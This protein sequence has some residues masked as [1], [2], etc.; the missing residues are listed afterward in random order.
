MSSESLISGENGCKVSFEQSTG[1]S[2]QQTRAILEELGLVL[3]SKDIQIG[4]DGGG[5]HKRSG[6]TNISLCNQGITPLQ[7]LQTLLEKSK[8]CSGDICEAYLELKARKEKELRVQVATVTAPDTRE[9]ENLQVD[10]PSATSISSSNNVEMSSCNGEAESSLL[11]RRAK[12]VSEK[13]SKNDTVAAVKKPL[14]ENEEEE[15]CANPIRQRHVALH[16]YYDGQNYSGLAENVGCEDDRSVER[17]LFAA[18]RKTQLIP[19]TS[20]STTPTEGELASSLQRSLAGY[21]RCGRTDRGVSAAGQVLAFRLKSAFGPRVSWDEDG[22]QLLTDD[23]LP[24]NSLQ[25]LNVF[26]FP[27]KKKGRGGKKNKNMTAQAHGN[28]HLIHDHGKNGGETGSAI[29][30][31]R[32]IQRVVKEI[33]YD[34]ILNN[35]LPPDIRVFGWTPVSHEFSARFSATTRTYRYFFLNKNGLLN[36]DRMQSALDL[37]VGEHDFRNFCKI[38]VEQVYNFVRRIHS[39]RICRMGDDGGHHQLHPTNNDPAKR[40]E[41]GNDND[42]NN[43]QHYGN[44]TCY[45]FEICGQAFLWHQIRCIVSI[46]FMVGRGLEE[47]S[48]VTDLLNV[49]KYQGKPSYA[50]ADEGP[51]VLHHCGYPNVVMGYHVANLWS[52]T[53]HLEQQRENLL[54]SASRIQNGIDLLRNSTSVSMDDTTAFC[55]ERLAERQKKRNKLAGIFQS[56]PG[57]PVITTTNT[58]P[59]LVSPTT[60]GENHQPSGG[61]ISWKE[62][63]VWMK[64]QGLVPDPNAEPVHIPLSRRSM[65]TT[66]EEKVASV[67]Q[68]LKRKTRYEENII[69]K[70]K[71]KEEDAAFYQ[72]MAQQGGSAL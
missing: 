34:K 40:G 35:V 61:L 49:Q 65:G 4:D 52:V 12:P 28:Q 50:M 68:S 57:H 63:L 1:E 14:E 71:P 39:A 38:N 37:L 5:G 58:I 24:K 53:C 45:Y 42:T 48:V 11:G 51:L 10:A 36:L 9:E 64:S 56:S 41:N 22:N 20:T 18:L 29:S 44:S 27:R 43:P 23:Q 7:V 21:S 59:Q 8:V 62:A 19:T 66:Y 33:A 54:L 6:G 2:G 15:S 17:A 31:S 32:R 60:G 67:H 25:A 55:Q 3:R 70:R 26:C 13:M 69:H 72:H 30:C 47:P 46:M 16:V